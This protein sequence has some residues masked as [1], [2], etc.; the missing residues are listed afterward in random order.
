MHKTRE[1]QED[2][3]KEM[4][5]KLVVYKKT[6]F[7]FKRKHTTASDPRPS[8]TA[9]G[10]M[11]VVVIIAFFLTFVLLDT[12][13]FVKMVNRLF[14]TGHSKCTKEVP[15]LIRSSEKNAGISQ[16]K[17]SLIPPL[18]RQSVSQ[19]PPAM[20]GA[21]PESRLQRRGT[22]PPLLPLQTKIELEKPKLHTKFKVLN[23][24]GPHGNLTG[25]NGIPDIILQ[26]H[27]QHKNSKHNTV[28][29]AP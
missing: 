2:D 14:K 6:T 24:Q 12:N 16:R 18:R 7:A 5:Q 25:P 13:N 22:L 4:V 10:S 28:G 3:V 29:P 15:D 1:Q 23:R 9:V 19:I 26:R 21:P 20:G 17:K 11:G 27:L 8:A